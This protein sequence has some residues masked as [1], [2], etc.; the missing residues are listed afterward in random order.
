[1][2]NITR[3]DQGRLHDGK[4]QDFMSQQD[5]VQQGLQGLNQTAPGG[6]QAREQQQRGGQNL[7][8]D[9]RMTGQQDKLGGQDKKE[10]QG[11]DSCGPREG[12][13]DKGQCH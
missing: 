12:K 4:K 3:D 7:Q 5:Q 9:I 11:S 2:S 8:R 1:M 10:C 6:M 13:C